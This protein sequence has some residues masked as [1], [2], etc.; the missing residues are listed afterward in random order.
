MLNIPSWFIVLKSSHSLCDPD[1]AGHKY[2]DLF[3]LFERFKQSVS[4]EGH[5]KLTPAIVSSIDWCS[6]HRTRGWRD[7]LKY[8]G[9]HMLF[10]T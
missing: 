9:P 3:N 10:E 4:M 5:W 1:C 7:K 2:F 8:C 6:A